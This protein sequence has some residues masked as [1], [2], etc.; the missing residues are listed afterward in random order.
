MHGGD[1]RQHV[2][3]ELGIAETRHRQVLR[4]PQATRARFHQDAVGQHVRTAHHGLQA[5]VLVQQLG[6]G[7]APQL[8]AA[9]GGHHGGGHL[10]APGGQKA[11]APLQG[12]VVA[13]GGDAHALQALAQE[14]PGQRTAHLQVRETDDHVHRAVADVPGLHH[15]YACP[16]QAVA[17]RLGFDQPH[18]HDAV[19]LAAHH[20]VQDVFLALRVVEGLAQQQLVTLLCQGGGERLHRGQELRHRQRRHDAGHHAAALGLEAARQQVGDVAGVDDR[21]LHARPGL[22]RDDARIAQRARRCDQRDA[23]GLCHVV[24]GGSFGWGGRIHGYGVESRGWS[25]IVTA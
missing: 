14:I 15:R 21:L 24:Q 7:L 19:R 20:G 1:G 11:F 8:Q 17:G 12:A 2:G 6:Q 4:H 25:V 5:G 16:A 13:A 18:H 10:A 9:G 3:A 22:F 23:G